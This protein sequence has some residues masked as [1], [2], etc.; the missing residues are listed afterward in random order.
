MQAKLIRALFLQKKS[1]LYGSLN[2]IPFLTTSIR[3]EKEDIREE[4]WPIKFSFL[5]KVKTMLPDF[6]SKNNKNDYQQQLFHKGEKLLMNECNMFTIVESLMKI[7]ASL[8]ILIDNDHKKLM[9]IQ[10]KYLNMA[11][12]HTYCK[13]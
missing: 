12:I 5:D 11:T 6:M 4:L 1:D 2:R 7:K 13:D 3:N 10:E 8:I 9:K